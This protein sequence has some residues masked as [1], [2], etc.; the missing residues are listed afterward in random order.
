MK[1]FFR[2]ANCYWGD[3]LWC[4]AMPFSI[5]FNYLV[6]NNH[7][8]N[9][10]RYLD[11]G[12]VSVAYR[13]FALILFCFYVLFTLASIFRI[14]VLSK[15]ALRDFHYL[16]IGAIVSFSFIFYIPAS[17]EIPPF[18]CCTH[19]MA[20]IDFLPHV[21]NAFIWSRTGIWFYKDREAK[22]AEKVLATTEPSIPPP[23]EAEPANN[24]P[25]PDGD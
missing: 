19:F 3:I 9:W 16:I 11:T 14:V 13:S 7:H 4:F 6:V 10:E 2:F 25:T 24:A 20:V 17:T 23:D 5:Y 12:E 21:N 1:K 18:M 22:K 8:T 15:W